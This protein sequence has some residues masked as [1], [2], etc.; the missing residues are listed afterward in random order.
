MKLSIIIPV[1]NEEETILEILNRVQNANISAGWEKE[2]IVVDNFSTDSTIDLL[3]NSQFPNVKLIMK[4][5]NRGKGHSVR[6]AIPLC[7]G[8]YTIT[9]DADLEYDPNDYYKLLDHAMQNDLDVVYGSRVLDGKYY[10]YYRLNY[11]VVRI[12]TWLTNYMF[13]SK[14]TDVA[15]NYKLIRTNLLQSL[16]LKCSGFD[17]D[18]E[19]SNKLALVTDRIDEVP[20]SYKPRS[21][22]EG[23]KI[24]AVD[25]ILAFWVIIRD[26]WLSIS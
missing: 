14:Y 4:K 7:T 10:H 20:I 1:F 2:I 15:T 23:K 6:M 8:M 9:Q 22:A 17:L 19:V 3:T 16:D 26:K 13:G 5:K 24:R 18:F 11:W 25:G 12:L 21:Y